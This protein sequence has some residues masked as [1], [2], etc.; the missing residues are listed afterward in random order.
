MSERERVV[1]IREPLCFRCKHL[2]YWPR[3][4]AFLN[5]IPYKVRSGK[6]L[7]TEPIEGDGGLVFEPRSKGES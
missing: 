7:H 1:D 6:N 2:I 5:G 3:C 4:E